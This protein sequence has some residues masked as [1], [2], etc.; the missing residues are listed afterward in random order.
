M[1]WMLG[2]YFEINYELINL[3]HQNKPAQ[4]NS[5]RDNSHHPDGREQINPVNVS[6]LSS[7]ALN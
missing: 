1:L 6:S 3:G 5:M 4:Q 2:M 7:Q